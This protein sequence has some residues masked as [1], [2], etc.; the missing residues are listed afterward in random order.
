MAPLGVTEHVI[1]MNERTGYK[2]AEYY[3]GKKCSGGQL[4][5]YGAVHGNC[6]VSPPVSIEWDMNLIS[7]ADRLYEK[8]VPQ[9]RCDPV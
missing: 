1:Y 6:A 4:V 5:R 2:I 9:P 8:A 3:E 7:G